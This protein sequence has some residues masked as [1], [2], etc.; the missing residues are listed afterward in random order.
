[1]SAARAWTFAIWA[2]VAGSAVA[3]GLKL[4]A[5]GPK[6][7][8]NTV[9]VQPAAGL[10]GDLTKLFGADAPPPVAQSEEPAPVPDARFQ[11]V[12]VLSP[13]SAAAAREGV[14][15]IAVDGN[16]PKA[17]RVGAVVQGDTVLQSVRPRAATLGPRDGPA[18]T[19]LE[20]APPPPPATGTLP[21]AVS[22][23]T[24]I[25]G[26]AAPMAMTPPRNP[27]VSPPMPQR[28]PPSDG[29]AAP[30]Q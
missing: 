8:V 26:N 18:Q 17:Y 23:G 3:W 7:P 15:L 16:P 29:G 24:N 11:L 2:L 5:Q 12:G 9:Q 4:F 28:P 22:G 13:R 30:L 27:N 14:A 10:R 1:M 25:G 20:L 6:A 21:P 19:T